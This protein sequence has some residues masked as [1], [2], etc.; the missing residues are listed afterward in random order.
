MKTEVWVE[1]EIVSIKRFA[2][3]LPVVHG[4]PCA[5]IGDVKRTFKDLDEF[6]QINMFSIESRESKSVTTITKIYMPTGE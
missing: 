2:V 6:V 3:R 1:F 5:T 4:V